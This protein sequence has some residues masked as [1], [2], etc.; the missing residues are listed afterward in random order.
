M[1]GQLVF[2]CRRTPVAPGSSETR[3][4]LLTAE[5]PDGNVFLAFGSEEFAVIAWKL[6]GADAGVFLLPESWMDESFVPPGGTGPVLVVSTPRIHYALGK[7]EHREL[8]WQYVI[9]YDFAAAAEASG[10]AR[11]RSAPRHRPSRAVEA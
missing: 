11:G 2:I 9:D 1:L 10:H 3:D 8:L 4:E 6:Y 7:R 5:L